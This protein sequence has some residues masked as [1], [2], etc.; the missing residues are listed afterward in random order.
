MLRNLKFLLLAAAVAT[1]HVPVDA[2]SRT[3]IGQVIANPELPMVGGGKIKAWGN[4]TANVMVFFRPGQE[5]SQVVLKEL[6]GLERDLTG[7]S[8]RWAGIVSDRHKPDEILADLKTADAKFS[9]GLDADDAYYSS[10]GLTLMPEVALVAKDGKLL[11][12]IPFA[13]VNYREMIRA[14]LRYV[15]GEISEAELQAALNPEAPVAKAEHSTAKRHIKMAEL[16]LNAGN[17]DKALESAKTAVQQAPD[18]AAAHSVLG[19]CLAAKGDCKAAIAEF[20]EALKL[21]KADARAQE[22]KKTCAEKAK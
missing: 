5:H 16:M 9:V 6:A 12:V 19:A 14:E 1:W 8:V 21:D 18:L 17:L 2:S 22:G 11:K 15:L 20:D 13:K 7:K 3:P 4:A 10:L